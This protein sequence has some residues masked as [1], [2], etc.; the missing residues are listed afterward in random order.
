MMWHSGT[1][2]HHNGQINYQFRA[3]FH[4]SYGESK[5]TNGA[6]MNWKWKWIG[7]WGNRN[8]TGNGNMAR[9][10]LDLWPSIFPSR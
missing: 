3:E 2:A 4:V 5:G 6:E 9:T 8:R 10:L 1:V 7:F